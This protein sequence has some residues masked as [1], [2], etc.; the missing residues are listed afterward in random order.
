MS[1]ATQKTVLFTGT[2]LP[3]EHHERLTRR[4]YNL[5]IERS[6]LSEAELIEALRGVSA[7][8][9]GGVEKANRKVIEASTDLKV[10]A[11]FGVG[12]E[13]Y[14]DLKAAT[15]NGIAVTN[16]P[17]ANSRSVAE[18][19]IALMLDAV[20]RTTYLIEAT[21]R[22]DWKE[23]K[24]WNL[25]G[26]TLGIIGMGTI[27]AH[28]ARIAHDGFGMSILYTSRTPK[29]QIESALKA[30]F[31]ALPEL[32]KACDV[33]SLHAATNPETTGMIGKA[34][35]DLMKPSSVLIN[36]SRA[37]LVDAVALKEALLSGKIRCAA[38]D[39][40]YQEPVPKAE[41]DQYGL[42]GLP[43]DKFLVSPH[44]AYFTEDATR[45]MADMVTASILEIMEGRSPTN[46]VNPD[47]ERHLRRA[48]KVGES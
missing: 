39:G 25:A 18:F 45:G 34:Q 13:S 8:I 31:V 19:T 35:L 7:Y 24:T 47:Y 4:G 17:G 46:L 30:K 29:S 42:V 48:V 2:A 40:Y 16:T 43:H 10:I 9:L 21:K 28:V 33:L 12:Y 23:E 6:D 1:K 5:K 11:F 32:L 15:D 27:G 37:E 38:F 36:C 3:A 44:T 14:V 22:G 41:D 20:K 26:K